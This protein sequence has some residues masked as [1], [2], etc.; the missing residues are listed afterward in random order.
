MSYTIDDIKAIANEK[1][2][3]CGAPMSYDKILK[4]FICADCNMLIPYV[5]YKECQDKNKEY[6][7]AYVEEWRNKRNNKN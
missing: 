3:E 4:S 6:V 2:P 5:T 1:C 7:A